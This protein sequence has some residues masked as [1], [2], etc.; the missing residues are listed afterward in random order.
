MP[1]HQQCTH[2]WVRPVKNILAM[3]ENKVVDFSFFNLSTNNLV[4]I[5][6]YQQIVLAKAT[7]YLPILEQ[8]KIIF[9]QSDRINFISQQLQGA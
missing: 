8:Q 2:F 6:K 1:N 4:N 7:D 9:N 5:D 3:F